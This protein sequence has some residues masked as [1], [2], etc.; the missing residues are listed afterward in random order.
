MTIVPVNQNALPGDQ[1]ISATLLL[2][3]LLQ[4][5]ALKIN[6][7][8]FR[9]YEVLGPDM[10]VLAPWSDSAT[11]GTFATPLPLFQVGTTPVGEP[12]GT[13]VFYVRR[14]H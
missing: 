4:L 11:R 1:R 13:L 3:C 5:Q 2:E 12:D 10:K 7:T 8:D 6:S 14:Q 9:G